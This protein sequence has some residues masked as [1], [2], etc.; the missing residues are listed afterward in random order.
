[1]VHLNRIST[2]SGDDGTTGLGDGSRVPKTD[3]RIV[4][5]G[6]VDELNA[7]IGVALATSQGFP[8]SIA[9]TLQQIQND[10]FDAGAELCFPPTDT[11]DDSQQPRFGIRPEYVERIERQIDVANDRL[12]PL[13]SF[14]LPGGSPLAAALH[15]ARAVCRRA[16]CDVLTLAEHDFVS[17]TLRQYLNRLSDLLFVYARLANHAGRADVLWKP[18]AGGADPDTES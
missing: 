7:T 17:A 2:K 13:E 8:T 16:E 6:S 4:A 14:V 1:M 18:G 15:Q 5:M 10:L 9:G 12:S 11:E 3:P